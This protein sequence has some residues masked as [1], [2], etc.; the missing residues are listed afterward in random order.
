MIISISYLVSE[1]ERQHVKVKNGKFLLVRKKVSRY[2]NRGSAT[3]TF[4]AKEFVEY[5]RRRDP[6]ITLKSGEK[7]RV[8]RGGNPQDEVIE[9]ICVIESHDER[10]LKKLGKILIPPDDFADYLDW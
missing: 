3:K 8:Y 6:Y 9:T 7:M 1:S 10:E 5:V 2:S 4:T